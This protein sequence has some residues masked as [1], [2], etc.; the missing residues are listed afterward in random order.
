[1]TVSVKAQ[2][3]VRWPSSPLPVEVA[4]VVSEG[5]PPALTPGLRGGS[6]KARCEW[7]TCRGA[8]PPHPVRAPGSTHKSRCTSSGRGVGSSH[9]ARLSPG[10]SGPPTELL[11][12]VLVLCLACF[13]G[14]PLPS[15][16]SP[17]PIRPRVL[18]AV[19]STG[20]EVVLFGVIMVYVQTH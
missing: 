20:L 1:M 18:P 17:R 11:L 16:L 19:P 8:A 13:T 5:H 10:P 7:H 14:L 4:P 3:S 12:S 15:L 6:G 2:H 9:D